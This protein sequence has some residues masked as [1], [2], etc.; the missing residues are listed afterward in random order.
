M[1]ALLLGA[2]LISF[3]G[4]FVKLVEAGPT[5]SAFYRMLFGGLVLAAYVLAR[6][7]RVRPRGKPLA[8]MAL[9]AALFAADLFFFHR[10]IQYVGVGLAT[11]LAA[12]QVFIL[13]VV[14]VF[15]FG[16]RLQLR[17]GASIALAVAGLVV[18]VGIDWLSLAPEYRLG[19]AYG[20]VTAACY[21]TYLLAL[22]GSRGPGASTS[23]A[24]NMAVISLACAALLGLVVI[25]EGGSFALA[26]G[27]DAGLL[28]LYGAT[29]QALAWVLISRSIASVPA[30]LVGLALLLQPALSFVWDIVFFARTF[31]LTEAAGAAMVLTAIWLGA[32]KSR[33]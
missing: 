9:A 19:V 5:V 11:L 8:Y 14:G 23:L 4:V 25:A 12:L 32:V 28:F 3:A 18:L 2:T 26:S 16:E 20:V 22:R 29:G 24:G 6:G 21:A 30:S 15:A 10:S 7:E 27:R 1:P 13:A 17:T 31:T 33:A